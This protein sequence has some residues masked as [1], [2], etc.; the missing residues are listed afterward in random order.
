MPFFNHSTIRI[1]EGGKNDG[2]MALTHATSI[3]SELE[4]TQTIDENYLKEFMKTY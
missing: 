4:E 1:D 2:F 3:Q